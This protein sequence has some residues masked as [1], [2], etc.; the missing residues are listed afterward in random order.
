[1]APT[2]DLASPRDRSARFRRLRLGATT[3]GALVILP[4]A[5]SSAYDAW[6]AYHNSLLATDRELGNVAKALAE[7]TAWTWQGID[8]LL[9]DT[10]AWYQNDAARI[11]P[12]RLDE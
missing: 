7:Q 4:F 8:L 2:D 6:R 12:E 5:G 9:R 10:A 11:A 1:M 3:L